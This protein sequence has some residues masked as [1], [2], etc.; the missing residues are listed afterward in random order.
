MVRSPLARAPKRRMRSSSGMTRSLHTMVE[1]AI[2][3]TITIPV[4]ADKPPT[5]ANRASAWWP[6]DSGSDSTKV[7][8]F[9]CPGPKCSSPPM[10]MG[11]TNRLMRKR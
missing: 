5:K 8:G 4:A 11:S 7:S 2:A 6:C 3:S 10:A 1:T 9:I